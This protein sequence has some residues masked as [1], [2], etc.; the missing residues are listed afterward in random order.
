MVKEMMTNKS[1]LPRNKVINL[2]TQWAHAI[3]DMIEA[4]NKVFACPWVAQLIDIDDVLKF[5]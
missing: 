2:V 1:E 3:T 4:A 5:I